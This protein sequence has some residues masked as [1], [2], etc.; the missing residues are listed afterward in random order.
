MGNLNYYMWRFLT[1]VFLTSCKDDLQEEGQCH[2][3]YTLINK[4]DYEIGL[5]YYEQGLYT[6]RKQ[7]DVL[8]K[9]DSV[10]TM[11]VVWD[12]IGSP[13]HFVDTIYVS[14][15]DDLKIE[16]YAKNRFDLVMFSKDYNYEIVEKSKH[17]YKFT[18]TITN[19]DYE[20]SKQKLAEREAEK[21]ENGN[22]DSRK[23][24]R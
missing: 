7:Y 21:E 9:K 22:G 23:G 20:Y 13:F 19:A 5:K 18:Y 15:G 2:A 8:I 14:Y 16:D 17:V 6:D 24:R 1:I 4:S 10:Y 3:F 12:I 11:D